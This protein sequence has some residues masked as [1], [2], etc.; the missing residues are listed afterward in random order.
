MI[1]SLIA[2]FILLLGLMMAWIE[3]Q[4][5]ARHVAEQHPEAGPLR[6]VGGGCGGHG[7][8]PSP[9]APKSAEAKFA[10]AKAA[11][12]KCGEA[13]AAAKPAEGCAACTNTACKPGVLPAA[14]PEIL[15]H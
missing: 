3:V 11:E 15:S 2:A 6:L 9:L 8:A 7:H 1:V 5:M 12:A 14:A 4:R 10:E 13:K